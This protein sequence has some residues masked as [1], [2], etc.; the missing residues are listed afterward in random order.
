[1]YASEA[2]PAPIAYSQFYALLTNG[3]VQSVVMSGEAI[4]A[5]LRVPRRWP[6]AP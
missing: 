6:A 5:T 2:S 4:D 1:M 3:K